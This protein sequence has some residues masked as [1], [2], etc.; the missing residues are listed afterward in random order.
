MIQGG[1]LLDAGN[2]NIGG[3]TSSGSMPHGSGPSIQ[4]FDVQ[5]AAAA[6]AAQSAVTPIVSESTH[7]A[8]GGGAVAQSYGI[9][10]VLAVPR[11]VICTPPTS[12]GMYAAGAPPVKIV[13]GLGGQRMVTKTVSQSEVQII[14]KTQN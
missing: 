5:Y 6:A 14:P 7:R 13:A 2:N 10:R 1:I 12:Y 9:K 4:Y 8:A 11:Q 3:A